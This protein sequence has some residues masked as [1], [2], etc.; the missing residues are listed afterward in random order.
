M[1]RTT[2][3]CEYFGFNF[4]AHQM[5]FENALSN[6]FILGTPRSWSKILLHYKTLCAVYD[7]FGCIELVICALSWS[8][9][10]LLVCL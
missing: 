9:L 1:T 6:Y 10:Y 4:H 2:R 5:K 8:V 3:I 7:T